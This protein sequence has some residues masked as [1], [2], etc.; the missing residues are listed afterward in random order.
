[1]ASGSEDN[2]VRLWDAATGQ[3]LGEPLEGNTGAVMS[4]AFSPDGT[5][6][7]SSS[8]DNTVRLW[9][10]VMGQPL[11][12]PLTG[13]TR[14]VMSVSF[15]PDGTR[16]TSG[17]E[18]KTVRLWSA[19]NVNVNVKPSSESKKPDSSAFSLHRSIAPSIQESRNMSIN[20]WNNRRILFSSSL[21]HALPNPAD[22]PEPTPHHNSY[23]TPFL[24]HG[25][26]WVMGPNH[27]L[28]FWV[29]P[30]SRH[31]FHTP[32]TSLVIPR[33][34]ELDLS[35]MAHGTHWS[36]CRDA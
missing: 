26:G 31:A 22:L 9:V 1:I 4:V 30:S 7:A 16:I 20:T 24:L 6:I 14:A 34:P 13:H 23:S 25:D 27:Q 15:S 28:L 2:T 11:G 33:D 36:S 18:D 12:E 5:R 3:P 8:S 29:P 10:A 19:V 32:W 17:S 21:R 35:R